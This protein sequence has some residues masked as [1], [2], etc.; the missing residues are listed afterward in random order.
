MPKVSICIPAYK[1]V[2]FLRKTLVSILAQDFEDYELIVTDDSTDDSVKKLLDEFDFRGRLRYFKN[3]PSLGSPANWNASMSK[4][5]GEYIKILHH[6]DFFTSD[7]SLRVFVK[8]LDDNAEASFAF[9]GTVIDLLALRTKK[10]HSC[11]NMQFAKMITYPDRLFFSNYIG[12]P[13]ATIIRNKGCM[14]FDEKLKWLVDVDWYMRLILTYPKVA[15]TKEPLVCTVHGG[16]GQITQSV[17][18][19][20]E[21]QIREHAYLFEKLGDKKSNMKKYS[22]LFQLLFDKYGINDLE[23]L[24]SIYRYSPASETFFEKALSAK[25]NGIFLKKVVFWLNKKSL[26]EHLFTLKTYFK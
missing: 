1:Q 21:I 2:E 20:S 7:H 6:D 23:K 25:K 24:R 13:S 9:S 26:N 18:N 14:L 22:V 15:F 19:D 12:A 16:E 5:T 4:A 8:L 11:S 3:T 17:F 10:I